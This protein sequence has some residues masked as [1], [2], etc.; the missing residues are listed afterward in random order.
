MFSASATNLSDVGNCS[1]NLIINGGHKEPRCLDSPTGPVGEFLVSHVR[2]EVFPVISKTVLEYFSLS[3]V[4]SMAE[5][6]ASMSRLD[7]RNCWRQH[8]YAIKNQLVAS[9]APY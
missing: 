6:S 9:K 8:S 3:R 7:P 5:F 4:L 1:N 2:I